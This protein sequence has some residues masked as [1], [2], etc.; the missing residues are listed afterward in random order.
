MSL[1]LHEK[2]HLKEPGFFR[3]LFRAL[4]MQGGQVRVEDERP[5]PR[6][7]AERSWHNG[8]WITWEGARVFVDMSDHVFQFDPVAL[9]EADLYLK[10]NLHRG[11]AAKV[12]VEKGWPDPGERLQPYT[13]LAPGLPRCRQVRWVAE[14]SG[15]RRSIRRRGTVCHIVGVYENL[16]RDGDP[17]PREG[18]ELAP[19][20]MHYWIRHKFAEVLR[21]RAPHGSTV[22]VVS[23]GNSELE[24]G[25]F[26]HPNLH[27]HSYVLSILRA[28]LLLLNT[29]PHAVYPWKAGEALA[30]G[31]PIAMEHE[32]LVE[33]PPY[34]RPDLGR[35]AAEALPGGTAGFDRERCLE[36]PAAYRVLHWPGDERIREGLQGILETVGNPEISLK[37]RKA[38]RRFAQERLTNRAIA[39]R[40][41]EVVEASAP[42]PFKPQPIEA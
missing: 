8:A 35:V 25:R 1:I 21:E 12:F 16:A 3:T 2:R 39:S 42:K 18:E 4:R 11:V 20:R 22:R 23:R 9:R 38:T 37:A 26:V 41:R 5:F 6:Y 19:N 17:E 14:A 36:D 15:L 7:R 40:F 10:A 28:D 31:V 13:F 32:P 33:I 29:L 24:D 27:Y 30:L 34:F